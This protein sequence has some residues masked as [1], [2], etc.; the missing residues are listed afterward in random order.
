MI[1]IVPWL[2]LPGWGTLESLE[3]EYLDRVKKEIQK[4]GFFAEIDT[5]GSDSGTFN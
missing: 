4:Y 5:N 3:P 1:N 2:G